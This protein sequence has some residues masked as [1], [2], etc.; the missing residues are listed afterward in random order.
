MRV[1]IAFDKFKD[2]LTAPEACEAAANAL[3]QLHP[4]WSL[5][6]CPLADGGEGFAAILTRAA[7][8]EICS[9]TVSGPLACV[10]V[11]VEDEARG[12]LV[13]VK[14]GLVCAN[15]IPAAARALL[16][17]PALPAD[18]VIAVIELA[19]ASGL[20]LL[21]PEQRDPWQTTTLG[22]GQLIRL[23]AEELGAQAVVL[24][25]GGSATNDLGLGAL[26]ALGLEFLTESGE[27]L[28]PPVPARWPQLAR[29]SGSLQPSLPPLRIAC[30]VDNPLLGPRG[31][32]AVFG[33]QK[34][35]HADDL[36]RLEHSSARVALMLC[37]HFHRPDALMDT[38]G[39]GAA[40]GTA[41]GLLCG[42][43][44]QLVPGSALVAA[45]LDLDARLAAA[46]VVLTGEGCYDA[47]SLAGKGPGAILAR[48]RALGKPAHVFA[49]SA[50]IS[51]RTAGFGDPAL[52]RL[53]IITPAG[54]AL[55]A[56]LRD[57]ATNLTR[58]VATAF[59]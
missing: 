16:A 33:P 31:A 58:A 24:G 25:V 19:Q 10:L 2:A 56:A 28:L 52:Q 45:W 51:A 38:P 26:A 7:G 49:G 11:S 36:R 29:I 12:G 57:A 37:A 15:Q 20:A 50:E 59:P 32:A 42:A 23:A 40:G 55:P 3:S 47:S 21:P 48:A 46:D 43:G 4:G 41:F 44:G 6:L 34:G 1:L 30:D 14:F 5:D 17:L 35:L 54:T 9:A 22:T 18:A 27:H 53:H 13:S 8:G 39:A